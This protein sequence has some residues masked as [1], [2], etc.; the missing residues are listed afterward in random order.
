MHRASTSCCHSHVPFV[1]WDWFFVRKFKFPAFILTGL[2]SEPVLLAV[3]ISRLLRRL[4]NV[5]R[6]CLFLDLFA[7]A[8]AAACC[9]KACRENDCGRLHFHFM[10]FPSFRIQQPVRRG[11]LQLFWPV[12]ADEF[13]VN[14]FFPL[15]IDSSFCYYDRSEQ[16]RPILRCRPISFSSVMMQSISFFVASLGACWFSVF[17]F[18]Y[19][20]KFSLHRE[21][22]SLLP[23]SFFILGPKL[24]KYCS[25]SS[26][27]FEFR[28]RTSKDI[29]LCWYAWL[30]LTSVA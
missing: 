16:I 25:K 9:F 2:Y 13:V 23:F 19:W 11:R 22:T 15:E 14:S 26:F 3:V 29:C 8:M 12:A 5:P 28:I 18:D 24:P 4:R 6:L 17:R 10:K 7:L 21:A 1:I 30:L 27:F 20:R